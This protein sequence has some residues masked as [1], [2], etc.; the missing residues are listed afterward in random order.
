MKLALVVPG[1]VDRS[2][3]YRV[4]PALLALIERLSVHHEVHVFALFQEPAPGGWDLLGARIHNI[5]RGA[6]RVRAI[7]AISREHRAA[8]FGLVQS[9]F[10]GACGLVAVAAARVLGIPCAV[11]VAGGEPVRLPD[12]RFGG[13]LTWRGRLQER[14]VLSQA[15]VLTAASAPQ[16]ELLAGL[17][18]EARRVPLGVDCVQ[19][20]PARTPVARQADEPAR[21]IHV[22]SLNRVKDQPT[23]LR[24]LAQLAQARQAFHVDIVGE[25]TLAG[26]IQRLAHELG[27]ADKL[28]FH[29]FMTQR[30]LLPLMQA[31]HVL[32]VSS[33]HEAGPVAVLEAAAVGVPT[34][35]TAVGHVTEWA[36]EGA[37]AVPVGDAQSLAA[38]LRQVLSDEALRLRLARAAWTRAVWEDADYTAGCFEAI[39]NELVP[40]QGRALRLTAVRR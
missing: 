2:G 24:A 26:E 1:G 18:A 22:A 21:L 27:L 34:V 8:P 23:L 12:I 28:Q 3:E 10:S 14:A 39:Y 9:F 30:Q 15:S 32:V 13:R 33:R 29:G 4:I 6:A 20:W 35:G 36:P 5:G 11:H 19:A 38:A 17:G 16:L 37:L 25:D 7:R 31:A 40:E